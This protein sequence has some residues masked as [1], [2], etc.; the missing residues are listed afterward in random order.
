MLV[1][2]AEREKRLSK[3]IDYYYSNNSSI[4]VR[5]CYFKQSDLVQ[6]KHYCFK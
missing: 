1:T 5:L 3:A 6:T 4:L 2:T